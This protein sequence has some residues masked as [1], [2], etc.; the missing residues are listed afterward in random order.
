MTANTTIKNCLF[1]WRCWC[2]PQRL[3]AKDL[4]LYITEENFFFWTTVAKDAESC[5]TEWKEP[6]SCDVYGVGCGV[7]REQDIAKDVKSY[8][9]EENCFLMNDPLQKTRNR[10]QM[11]ERKHFLVLLMALRERVVAKDMKSCTSV[12]KCG[13]ELLQKT[14]K[15]VDQRRIV[16]LW[17]SYYK[18][19]KIVHS[20]GWGELFSYERDIAKVMKS[21]TAEKNCF[22]MN[23]LL[24]KAWNR[25]SLRFSCEQLIAKDM[26]SSI[27]EKIYIA[28][29]TNVDLR[30]TASYERLVAKDM[31]SYITG[32]NCFFMNELLQKTWNRV[33]PRR[34]VFIWTRYGKRHEI[35]YSLGQPFSCERVIAK[36]MKSC[37]TEENWLLMN[38]LLQKMWNR[39]QLRRTVWMWA[40]YCKRLDIMLNWGEYPGYRS[41]W[42]PELFFM[43]ELLQKSW[44]RARPRRAFKL[45]YN[46]GELFPYEQVIAKKYHSIHIER[47][48]LL[49][50]FI[51]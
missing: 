44:N 20:C 13:D 24:Q 10:A 26:E 22:L 30:K 4:K 1:I 41:P 14:R 45:V 33:Q 37:T 12:E 47:N 36:D 39:V 51:M 29:D 40:S 50:M 27:T 5:S 2:L 38:K 9:T 23:E 25:A 34:P 15:H 49:L 28:D 43:N 6:F 21:C 19:L 3:I 11:N 42:V 16:F 32:E 48:R 8:V 17:T 18:G 7:L 31:K 46:W 35:A